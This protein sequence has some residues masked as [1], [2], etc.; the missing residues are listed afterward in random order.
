MSAPGD[1]PEILARSALGQYDLQAA[2]FELIKKWQNKHLFRVISAEEDFL[3]RIYAPPRA[4]RLE[5][6]FSEQALCSKLTWMEALRR[7]A[8]LRIPEPVRTSCGS[9]TVQASAEGAAQPQTA[10]LLRWVP[11][12]VKTVHDLTTEDLYLFGRHAARLHRHAEGYAPPESFFRPRWDWNRLFGERARLWRVGRQAFSESE[13][14][15]FAAVAER[16]QRELRRMG[17]SRKTYGIV[18][19]DL[20]PENLVFN[21]DGA[22]A[23]DFEGCGWSY[24]MYDLAVMLLRLEERGEDCASLESAMLEGYSRVRRLP[25]DH[26]LILRIFV[27]MRIVDKVTVTLRLKEPL[28]HPAARAFLANAVTRLEEILAAD[29]EPSPRSVSSLLKHALRR[30]RAHTSR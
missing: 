26:Q 3:L 25:G 19:R 5:P 18:H 28:T 16:S 21:E 7:E 4:K 27:A 13:L 6:S 30:A 12:T 8:G 1:I 2:S 14:K 15:V 29:P 10:L 11:G 23:I 24:Y 17:K 20:Q 22:S 9:L